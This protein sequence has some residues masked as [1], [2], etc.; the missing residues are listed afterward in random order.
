MYV[1]IYIAAMH[2]CLHV[3]Y[4]CINL[5]CYIYNQLDWLRCKSKSIFSK[6]CSNIYDADN[7]Q[8]DFDFKRSKPSLIFTKS[9]HSVNPWFE[10]PI[11]DPYLYPPVLWL[12]NFTTPLSLQLL[13]SEVVHACIHYFHTLLGPMNPFTG[14]YFHWLVLLLV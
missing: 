11:L 9:A 3:L 8:V 12:I 1:Y 14:P 10:L 13:F 4:T 6:T 5:Q 2:T 7:S